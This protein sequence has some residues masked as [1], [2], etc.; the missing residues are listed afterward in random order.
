MRTA[1]WT[2]IAG[3]AAGVVTASGVIYAT[4]IALIVARGS[5][6]TL[7][8][9]EATRWW[10]AL[11]T[12]GV[13]PPIVVLFW[14][15]HRISRPGTERLLRWSRTLALL[16]GVTVATS[17]TAFLSMGADERF[18]ATLLAAEI[19]GW[20]ILLGLAMVAATPLFAVSRPKDIAV[21]RL[22]LV[23]A[24]LGLSSA[25]AYVAGSSWYLVGFLAWGFVL[26]VWTA[27]VSQWCF[28]RLNTP[29]PGR[30]DA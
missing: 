25:A 14:S 7:R 20:G 2:R 8:P 18:S 10:A 30:D 4:G 17:R 24:A 5:G 11:G 3:W 22:A 1:L 12:L 6:W 9:S 28:R 27:R 15:L 13:V 23:Y 21:G 19:I 26:Y 16:F 29:G